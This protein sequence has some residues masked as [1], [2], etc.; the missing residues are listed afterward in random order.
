MGRVREL[1]GALELDA[2][3]SGGGGGGGDYVMGRVLCPCPGDALERR[4]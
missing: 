3:A 1:H 2:H 4:R